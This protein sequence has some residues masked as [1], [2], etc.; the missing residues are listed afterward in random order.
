MAP[1]VF[2][3]KSEV[4]ERIDVYGLGVMLYEALSG[5]PP[6]RETH[7][8]KLLM[9]IDAGDCLPLDAVVDVPAPVASVVM[10][11]MHRRV[12]ERPISVT[13]LL[14]AWRGAREP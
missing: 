2:T 14:E 13:A 4:N 8:G 12:E 10:S 6:F 9:K 3:G 7:V 5:S 1:E 11:A